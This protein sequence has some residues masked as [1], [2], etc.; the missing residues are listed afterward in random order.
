MLW[1]YGEYRKTQFEEGDTDAP[2][3]EVSP[4]QQPTETNK[5]Y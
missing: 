1:L 5:D 3:F 4:R 2:G